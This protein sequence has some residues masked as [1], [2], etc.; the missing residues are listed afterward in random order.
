M[1]F[2][3]NTIDITNDVVSSN[4][5]I[6]S[7][8]NITSYDNLIISEFQLVLHGAAYNPFASN[9]IFYEIDNIFK[10]LTM[11]IDILDINTTAVISNI[12]FDKTSLNCTLTLTPSINNKFNNSITYVAYNKAPAKVL[13]DILTLNGFEQNIDTISF[14]NAEFQQ[15]NEL[16]LCDFVFDNIKIID[17]A[18]TI[19]ELCCADVFI[20]IDSKIYF[21]QYNR[22]SN[23]TSTYLNLTLSQVIDYNQSKNARDILNAYKITTPTI[24]YENDLLGNESILNYGKFVKELNFDNNNGISSN[25]SG[26]YWAGEN[27]IFRNQ[28]PKWVL[29]C[30]CVNALNNP[31]NLRSYF[32]F[33][34]INNNVYE[35]TKIEQDYTNK[36]IKITGSSL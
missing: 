25:N 34:E 8:K 3:F 28:N 2:I 9:S 5:A 6:Q 31:V 17:I 30:N 14:E 10:S 19:G 16:L 15:E 18:N 29:E 12:E 35:I 13:K 21:K 36:T 22:D 33:T 27:Y 32:Q 24:E 7:E 1:T 23:I 4:Y 11:E 26:I 20:D